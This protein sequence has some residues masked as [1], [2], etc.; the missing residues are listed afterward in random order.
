MKPETAKNCN[1]R[2]KEECLLDQQCLT[3]SIVYN[4]KTT[5]NVCGDV[6]EYIGDT[7]GTFKKRY[8]NHVKSLNNHLYSTEAVLPKYAWTLA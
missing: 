3:T 4:A 6:K 7:A 1:C 5:N 8:A 2:K